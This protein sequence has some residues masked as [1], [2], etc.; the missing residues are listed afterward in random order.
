[1]ASARTAAELTDKLLAGD[2]RALARAISLVENDDPEGWA[3]VREVYP[4]TGKAAVVGFTGPPG[5]GKSTLIGALTTQ[6][7]QRDRQVAVLSIDPSSPFTKGALLGDRI[8]LTEH[9]LDSGVFIRSMANRGALGGL[10]EACLQAALLMDASGKDVVLLETVGVGQAEVDI[11]DHAD[12]VV[13]ALM[14]GSGDSIQALKAGVMEIPDVIV[15]NKSDHPLTDT[16]IREI[17]GVLS[18]GPQEGWRVPIV[19]TEASRGE[20]IEELAEAIEAH[21]V[22]IEAEGTLAERRRR[23]LMN[24]VLALAAGRLR[25]RLEESLRDDESVRE[26]LD[27]VVARRLDPSSAATRLLEREL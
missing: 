27:E 24:E 26:L 19:K 22:H 23:N 6:Y 8:R 1:M 14:P 17:R 4:R 18:L 15:V 25:R 9:F 20:G 7:R 21:R 11:I 13:L 3:L 12:T 16:M 2:K 10:S 5:V